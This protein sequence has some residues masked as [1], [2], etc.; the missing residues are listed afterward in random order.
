[1][2]KERFNPPGRQR[3]PKYLCTEQQSLN[4][5]EAKL[6]ELKEEID[7]STI[8]VEDFTPSPP[9]MIESL[10]RKRAGL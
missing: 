5:H 7:K 9:E 4:I 8:V 2:M 3:D 10:G 1:M 6:I